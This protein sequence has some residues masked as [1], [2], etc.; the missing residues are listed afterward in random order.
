M[1][2]LITYPNGAI[3][4]ATK[5]EQDDFYFPIGGG[6]AFL[7]H[8]EAKIEPLKEIPN[9]WKKGKVCIEGELISKAIWDKNR[10][11]NGWLMP[12]IAKEDAIKIVAEQ[13]DKE[14][15]ELKFEGE[16]ILIIDHQYGES[17][18]IICPEF[19]DGEIYYDFGL[20]GWIWEEYK[21]ETE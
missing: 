13:T 2:Y 17:N 3:R 8:T 18:E 1:N 7:P 10:R 5:R 16:N 11:W 21:H 6:F 15:T 9:N 20:L 19:I 12:K 4:Y 14:Y